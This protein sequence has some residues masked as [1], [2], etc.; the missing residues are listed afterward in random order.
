MKMTPWLVPAILLVAW[1]A[2]AGQPAN[3][4]G[5]WC[6]N[7]EKSSWESKPQP[8]AVM[9]IIEHQEPMLEYRGQVTSP[10]DLVRDFAFKGAIDG[11][12]YPMIRSMGPGTAVLYRINDTTFESIFRTDDGAGTETTRTSVSADGRRLTRKIHN[13]SPQGNTSWVEIYERR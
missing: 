2:Y 6:L 1:G 5:T 9:L 7:L 8:H 10:T 4:T 11:K 13:E 3:I 12:R